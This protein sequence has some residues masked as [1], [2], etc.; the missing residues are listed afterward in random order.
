MLIIVTPDNWLQLRAAAY[1]P[2][3]LDSW[4]AVLK[5]LELQANFKG[6]IEE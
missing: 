3:H 1:L 5:W 4:E 2:D 6:R